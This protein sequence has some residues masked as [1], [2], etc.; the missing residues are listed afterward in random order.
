MI[1]VKGIKW[2]EYNKEFFLHLDKSNLVAWYGWIFVAKLGEGYTSYKKAN[3]NYLLKVIRNL[4]Y[5]PGVYSKGEI[6]V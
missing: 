2:T 6:N 1:T 4:I 5:Q 3:E